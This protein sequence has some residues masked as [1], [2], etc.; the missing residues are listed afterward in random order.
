MRPANW[1]GITR[2]VRWMSFSGKTSAGG[3]LSRRGRRSLATAAML[4]QSVDCG[5]RG[6]KPGG[7]S[8]RPLSITMWPCECSLYEWVSER[9]SAH[10]S[11]RFASR[12]RCS[13]TRTPGVAVRMAPNAPR[14]SAGASGFGSKLSC[15]A[16][17]PERKM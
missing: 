5:F 4:G 15:W 11:E 1:P 9:T 8:D 17:P 12:G 6:S 13:Q 14:T 3:R 16:R 10:F 2:P 7:N